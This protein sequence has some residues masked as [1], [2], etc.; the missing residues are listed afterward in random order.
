MPVLH[1]QPHPL[2]LWL[3]CYI[4]CLVH[5]ANF[6]SCCIHGNLIPNPSLRPGTEA[7]PSHTEKGET[8]KCSPQTFHPSKDT[9]QMASTT[10]QDCYS[11]TYTMHMHLHTHTP[12]EEE[13][14]FLP[15]WESFTAETGLARE[16]RNRGKHR[17]FPE[18]T[19][20]RQL[21]IAHSLCSFCRYC[22]FRHW[23]P[24]LPNTSPEAR[25]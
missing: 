4:L 23:T 21:D 18:G 16:K 25:R 1:P 13:K 24:T 15:S 22:N 5:V 6:C 17:I 9:R 19:R 8:Y 2:P 10:T 3:S 14:N 11:H 12:W 7:N 20:T